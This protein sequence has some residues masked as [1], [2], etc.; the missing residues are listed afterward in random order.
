MFRLENTTSLWLLLLLPLLVIGITYTIKKRADLL[1][2]WGNDDIIRSLTKG[3]DVRYTNI[4]YGLLLAAIALGII[5]LANPQWGYSNENLKRNAV[6]VFVAL[7][8]SKSM[9]VEDIAPSRIIRAKKIA[10]DLIQSLKGNNI[11]LIFFAGSAYMQMP[12]TSDYAAAI[13]MVNAASTDLAGTQGTNINAIAD[14]IKRTNEK[15]GNS[16]ANLI[17][18]T[19]GE[20]HEGAAV[21]AIQSLTNDGITTYCIG[22]GTVEGGPIHEG[23]GYK[24][25]EDNKPILSKLNVDL[26]NDIAKAGNGRAF[27]LDDDKAVNTIYDDVLKGTKSEKSSKSFNQYNSYFQLFVFMAM[28]LLIAEYILSKWYHLQNTEV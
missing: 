19:D 26:I 11:G 13:M 6:D 25:D 20:D 18:I 21:D 24:M 8:I 7:D 5:A 15:N 3:L 14:L 17:I 16:N 23:N 28:A 9:D 12:L 4:R 1:K 10:I 27:G 22:A 2:K